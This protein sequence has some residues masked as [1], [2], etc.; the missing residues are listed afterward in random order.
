MTSRNKKIFPQYVFDLSLADPIKVTDSIQSLV[1][2]QRL[3]LVESLVIVYA[4]VLIICL[5]MKITIHFPNTF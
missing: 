2:I 5:K 3:W 1:L 4:S